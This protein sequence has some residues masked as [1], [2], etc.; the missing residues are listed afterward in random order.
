M[1]IAEAEGFSKEKAY[2][3]T[4]LDL[5]VELIRN[6]TVSWKK[7]GAPVEG[8]KLREFLENYIKKE[9]VPGVMIAV[10]PS[11]DDTRQRPYTVVNEVTTGRRKITSVYQIK[12]ATLKSKVKETTNEDGE[13][14]KE[15]VASV[16]STGLIAGKANKKGDALDI[17]K[18]LIR[19]N[20]RDYVI[21]IAGEVTQGQKYAAYG[22]YTPSANAKIGKFIFAVLD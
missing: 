3:E 9:R 7:A 22:L 12:E 20:R 15:T 16:V 8:K 2:Q 5:N 4:G 11:S 21:E 13:T 19:D 18:D 17:M 14:V 6:A 10:T 1:K